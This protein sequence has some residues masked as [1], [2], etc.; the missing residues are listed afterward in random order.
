M[1]TKAK[2]VRYLFVFSALWGFLAGLF[3]LIRPAGMSVTETSTHNG[4]SEIIATQVSF[5]EMQ[6]W[7]GIWILIAFAALYYGPLHF[8][9]RGSR[10]LAALFAATAIVLS[11]LAIFSIGSFYF[12]AA[13]ALL[14]G[15]VL[16]PFTQQR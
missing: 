14:V 11:L 16:L 9:S 6:G 15:L 4:G 10:G 13:L 7:W 8:C 5:F 12:P 2:I 1:N 3:I